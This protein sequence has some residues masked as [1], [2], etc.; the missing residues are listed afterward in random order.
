MKTFAL[1]FVLILVLS[2]L[3][4]TPVAARPVKHWRDAVRPAPGEPQVI[5]SYTAGCIQGAQELPPDGPGFQTIRRSRSSFF[6]HPTLIQYIQELGQMMDTE[7]LGTLSIGDLGQARGGPM[8]FAHRSHQTGLDVDIWFWLQPKSQPMSA[9]ERE[10]TQPPSMVTNGRLVLDPKRWTSR[11]MR[12]MAAAASFDRVER[13]FVT[14]PVKQAL[15]KIYPGAAWLRKV[16]PWWGH[17]AHFHVRLRCPHGDPACV[18]QA[19][20]P[21]GDG[22]DATLAWWF[23]EEAR[24]PPR[25]KSKPAP[26]PEACQHILLAK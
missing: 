23:S 7:G 4:G 12:L 22:C 3:L 16:R 10:T 9:A 13:I 17:R 6:G 26:L 25:T 20:T 14:P 21:K 1:K 18:R 5:G 24:H 2:V 15:C 19:P 11:Q 8:P